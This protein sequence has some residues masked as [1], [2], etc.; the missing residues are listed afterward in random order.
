VERSLLLRTAI[1]LVGIIAG[2]FNTIG[3]GGSLLV[4]LFLSFLGMDVAV[5]NGTNR[6]GIVLQSIAGAEVYRKKG[7]LCFRTVLP[8]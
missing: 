8:Q 3:G 5:A 1:F 7:V 4:L 6:L 2:F